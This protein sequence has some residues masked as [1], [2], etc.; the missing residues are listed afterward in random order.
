[1]D[2]LERK[3]ER[4]VI[5]LP[6]ELDHHYTEEIRKEIDM[7]V[8]EEPI[9][10]LEFDFS[11]TVFMDSA[12]IGMILG[13]YKLM[14]ALDGRIFASHMSGQI[15][16]VLTLSGIQKHICLEKEEAV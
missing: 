10:E 6:A 12:G 7:I 3:G 8:R 5:H 11:R 15:H 4:L 14:Q 1:M 2:M 13:R 16:R 9:F